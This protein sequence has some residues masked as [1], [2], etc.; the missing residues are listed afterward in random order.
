MRSVIRPIETRY[1]GCRFRSR[2]EARWAVFFDAVEEPWEY[3]KEG[4]SLPSGPYLP[5]FWLPRPQLWVEV[6]GADATGEERNLCEELAWTTDSPVAILSGMPGHIEL[7]CL[8]E[9]RKKI[10]AVLDGTKECSLQLPARFMAVLCVSGRM[11]PNVF[12]SRQNYN[13][14]AASSHT[15]IAS[16][17]DH[18][19][20]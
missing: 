14:H 5:D 4:Y 15:T 8:L 17:L 20:W 3:E 13:Q 7:K 10:P 9:T 19:E 2:V 1:S 6:K 16:G 18:P 11:T 12:F